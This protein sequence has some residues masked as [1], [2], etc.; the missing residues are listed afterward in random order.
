MLHIVDEP[1]KML[2][3]IERVLRP[4]GMLCML[5]LQRSWLG[6]FEK[7]IKASYTLDKARKLIERSS[8]RD[9]KFSKDMLFWKFEA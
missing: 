1:L 6:L 2:D 3:E 8:M 9:G 5:D 7:E 4:D